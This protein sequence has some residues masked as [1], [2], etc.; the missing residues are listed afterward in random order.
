MPVSVTEAIGLALEDRTVE[1]VV[2]RV[3]RRWLQWSYE[4]DAVAESGNG[5]GR[6][7]GVLLALLGPSACWGNNIRCEDGTDIDTGV[8]C[9]RC[10]EAREDKAAERG[11]EQPGPS[12]AYSI[13]FERTDEVP[14][15]PKCPSCKLPLAT[16]TEPVLC[17][18]C[19]EDDLARA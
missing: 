13:Q 5:L 9:P 18:E 16:A 14:A 2:T 8:I 6:P 7:L 19:R 1:Q 10:E 15:R 12:S 11:Q 3:E 17:R 4:N